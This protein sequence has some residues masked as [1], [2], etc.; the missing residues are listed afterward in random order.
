M[1][2]IVNSLGLMNLVGRET[3][4][5]C[6]CFLLIAKGMHSG[7]GSGACTY[8]FPTKQVN[9]GKRSRKVT[10]VATSLVRTK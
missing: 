3:K 9:S 7:L 1:R 10:I 6:V 4:L 2:E 5:V 8:T